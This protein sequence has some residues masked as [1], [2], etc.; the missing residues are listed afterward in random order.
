MKILLLAPHP[1]FQHRGTPIAVRLM[2]EVL[3]G[4][5][6][7]VDL[8]CFHEG[9][10]VEMPGLRIFRIAAPAW[11]KGVRPGFSL[12][13]LACD[14]Y[15]WREARTRLREKPYDL[16][17]AVEEAVFMARSLGRRFK[18]P[19]VYDMDSSLAA[20]M[21]EK[22]A[23]LAPVA[24]LMRRI[25][26][27]AVRDSLGVVAVCQA[28]GDLALQCDPSCSL[29]CLEDISLL[30]VESLREPAPEE[31]I[32]AGGPV[33]MY[34]GNLEPYQGLDLLLESFR[35]VIGQGRTAQLVVIGGQPAAIESYQALAQ[36]LGLG[37]RVIFT[38]PR[39]P[40]QLGHFLAQATVVVSPRIKGENTPMKVYSYLD[41]GRPLLATRLPTHTQVL[42]E[43]IAMLVEPTPEDMARGLLALLSDPDL[44]KRLSEAARH[45]VAQEYS[46]PA[47]REKL[48]TFYA[49]LS[50]K[51]AG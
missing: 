3:T 50:T 7:Q 38:G 42:D 29:L 22:M 44:R 37:D 39:P 8:V 19:Y 2:A 24:P 14:F 11:L 17:H 36:R 13:K 27:D 4:A 15:F 43:S 9:E 49:G 51:L 46:L 35:L 5:G 28:L 48:L 18:V 6:H 26:R 47:Y 20:Q 10:D 30:G 31:Q 21:Q 16:I 45:R 1:F 41:S 23:W 32:D 40:G 34:V 33:V 12:K 25:E